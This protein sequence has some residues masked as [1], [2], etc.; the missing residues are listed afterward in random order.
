M[1]ILL[2]KSFFEY[3]S[4]IDYYSIFY[5]VSISK[6]KVKSFLP[7]LPYRPGNDMA[8]FDPIFMKG[9]NQP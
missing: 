8:E 2:L 7:N 6:N 9:N 4:K 3:H 1:G 5:R